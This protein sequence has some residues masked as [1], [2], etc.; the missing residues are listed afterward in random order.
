MTNLDFFLKIKKLP[1]NF[2]CL[3]H[4][5][6]FN[7]GSFD[8]KISLHGKLKLI[9]EN[10]LNSTYIILLVENEHGFLILNSVYRSKGYGTIVVIHQYSITYNPGCP[11]IAIGK[12]LY[13]GYE[14]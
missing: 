12:R 10:F 7:F 5:Q 3:L 11:F 2:G 13:V 6:V 1:E 8:L 14:N 9:N 4:K